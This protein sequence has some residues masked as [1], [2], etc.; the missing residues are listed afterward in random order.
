MNNESNHSEFPIEPIGVFHTEQVNTYD[1]GRQ[2]DEHSLPGYIELHKGHNFEQALVGLSQFSHIW[3]LFRFHHN[4]HWK[5]MVL[6]PRGIDHKVGVFAT[7][8]PY[9]PNGIGMSALKLEKI[10]GLRLYVAHSDLLDETPILDIKP[11]LTYSDSIPEATSGWIASTP[12]SIRFSPVCDEMLDFLEEKGLSTLRSF[13]QHQ[14]EFAP[15]DERRKRVQALGSDL[16]EIAYRTWRISFFLSEQ[17]IT[18]LSIYSGYSEEELT[19]AEDPFHDKE[20]HQQF[21]KTF[22]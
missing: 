1:A 14:L 18:V 12:F 4:T 19:N 13:I 6:P 15:T 22:S 9:R 17:D 21:K 16:W 10:E 8:S 3:V 5:P 7:R 2:S 20:L 11:Y